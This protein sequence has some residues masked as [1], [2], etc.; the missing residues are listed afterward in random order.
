MDASV[1]LGAVDRNDTIVTS[2][3]DDIERLLEVLGTE[4]PVIHV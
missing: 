3:P 2:D 1:V 4:L